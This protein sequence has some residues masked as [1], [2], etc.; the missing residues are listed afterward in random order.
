LGVF[1]GASPTVKTLSAKDNQRAFTKES[2]Q[3]TEVLNAE[4][5]RQAAEEMK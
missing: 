5:D 3:E 1:D 2:D 4:A